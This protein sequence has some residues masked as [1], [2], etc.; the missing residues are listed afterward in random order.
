MIV[1]TLK[2]G[3]EIYTVTPLAEGPWAVD[4]VTVIN[5]DGVTI[6]CISTVY[7]QGVMFVSRA[8]AFVDRAVASAEAVRRN[9][10]EQP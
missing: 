1:P 4:E 10:K 9:E 6:C 7:D 3:A 5:D 2:V 8:D